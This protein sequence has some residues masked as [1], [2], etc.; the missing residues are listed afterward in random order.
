MSYII[1]TKFLQ[2]CFK[3]LHSADRDK[4]AMRSLNYFEVN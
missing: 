3:Y 1:I 2:N 4:S